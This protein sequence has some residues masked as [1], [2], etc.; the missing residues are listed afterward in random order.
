MKLWT[1][2]LLSAATLLSA[3]KDAPAPP[4]ASGGAPVV[5]AAEQKELSLDTIS[6]QAQGF[7]VGPAM[8]ARVVYVFFDPQCPHCANLW[9]AAKPLKSQARFVWIPVSLINANSTNQGAALLAAQDPVTAMDGHEAS[10]KAQRGGI[11]AEGSFDAQKAA[12]KKN[13]ELFN[14]YGFASVPTIVTKN[15]QGGVVKREGALPTDALA[16]FIGV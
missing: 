5:P 15:A 9:A 12:I 6:T 14:T 4:A 13:T 7:S 11:V 3:C 2:L 10:L 16:A 8:S 1:V